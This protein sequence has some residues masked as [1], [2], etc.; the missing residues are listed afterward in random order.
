MHRLISLFGL[1]AMIGFAWLLSYHR[2]KVSWRVVIGGVI[3]QFA[4]ASLILLTTPGQMFF[5]S[6][7]AAFN[8]MMACVDAGSRFVFGEHFADHYFAF[9]VLPSIIFFSALM[10]V[11]YYL[12]IMQRVVRAFGYVVQRTL[13]TTGTESLAAAA[14]I[15]LGQTEAPLVVRP[16]VANMTRSEL[17]AVMV[18]GFGSTAGGVLIAFKSMGIDAG[19]LLTASVLSAPASLLIAKV[20]LPETQHSKA[21]G[22]VDLDMGDTG[23]NVV[24]A[25]SIGT[26]EGLKLALN[27]GAMLISFIALIAL[28]DLLLGW[29][30]GVLNYYVFSN[31]ESQFGL[32]WSLAAVF[33]YLFAPFAWLM[34]IPWSDCG[35]AG[36]LLGTK[37]VTN[38][39]LAY[40]QLSEWM[41]KDSPV[42]LDPRSVMILTYAL[43]G[44]AN[45]SSIGIQI[46]GIG[47]MAPNRRGDLAKLG[48]R[49]MLGGT[50]ACFMTACVVGVLKE[51]TPLPA[52][53]PPQE[54]AVE[55]SVHSGNANFPGN[56]TAS[57]HSTTSSGFSASTNSTGRSLENSASTCRQ[58]PQGVW[59]PTVAMAMATNLR[60]PA[61]TA[62]NTAVRSAQ[63]VKPYEAFST[64]QPTKIWPSS[65][66]SA[67]PTK[68]LEYGAYAPVRASSAA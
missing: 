7:D 53:P 63:I 12:G 49:A 32:G 34:G 55:E 31:F 60:L 24:E 57:E 5:G 50:L 54:P 66:S 8:K 11:L 17:M 23:D 2:T 14:N 10:Q 38:E 29:T 28:F 16:Y 64:L 36:E 33:S 26:I 52:D 58:A 51:S 22:E 44:F 61:A 47:G 65:V 56:S 67:A 20:I 35:K 4:F 43:C 37:M 25:A 48:L 39:F 19:H 27:V 41:K 45:F 9:R 13:G 62:L 46:G 1:C 40:A 18:P 3:L 15:F 68:N 42:T 30:G 59:P 6:V 21:T